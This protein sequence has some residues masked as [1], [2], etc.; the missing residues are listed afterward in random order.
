MDTR[1]LLS[2]PQGRTDPDFLRKQYHALLSQQGFIA[3]NGQLR[4]SDFL[5][6][7]TD[8][9]PSEL[10]GLLHSELKQIRSPSNS[11]P[12]MI[13]LS[14]RAQH[15]LRQLLILYFLGC[16]VEEFF[17]QHLQPQ[18]PFGEGPWPCLNPVCEY[19]LQ[20]NIISYQQVNRADRLV[21]RFACECGFTYIRTGPDHS[22]DDVFRRER[23]LSFGP[24][25]EM[26]L[27]EYWT[28]LT[29]SRNDISSRLGINLSTLQQQVI[30]LQLPIPRNPSWRK[31]LNE[32]KQYSLETI[33]R[34]RPRVAQRDF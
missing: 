12:S 11:W 2:N 10:L 18:K 22:S 9:Y 16:R 5:I 4:V 23:I 6:S 19:Y 1:Y 21:G 33:S 29:L 26:K 25:W 15:P 31:T 20:R 8:Y 30:K 28:D 3:R 27:R 17:H 32:L 24:R 13:L 7:F 34:Y 14:R